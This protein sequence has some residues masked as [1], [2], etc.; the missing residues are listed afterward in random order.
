MRHIALVS[1]VATV[2]LVVHPLRAAEPLVHRAELDAPVAAVWKAFTDASE[3]KQWM[4]PLVE[5]DLRVGGLMRSNYNADGTLGDENT[6]ENRILAFEPECMLSIRAV[7]APKD[8]PFADLI[9]ETWSVMHF[10]PL[11]PNRT[12]IRLVGMGYGEGKQ[13]KQMRDFFQQGNQ[14]TLDRLREHLAKTYPVPVAT[15]A[16]A[17]LAPL[18]RFIGEWRTHGTWSDGRALHARA[19][20]TWGINKQLIHGKT[21]V[22]DDETG[23]NEYQRYE[24][25]FHFDPA[26]NALVDSSM[27]VNGTFK[28]AFI[29]PVDADTT[30]W[31]CSPFN[32]DDV[33]NVRQT[34]R[35]EDDD[36]FIW[37]VLMR[38]GDS[39]SRLI[40]SR[41][42]REKADGPR[43]E[44]SD[45]SP[46]RPQQ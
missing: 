33:V 6:I 4:V 18:A 34:I 1:F 44:A 14:W 45:T 31:G 28:Q 9:A 24:S 38:D 2:L 26:R 41:W 29:E 11:S 32:P 46:G 15:D 30:S 21:W 42:T 37:T 19:S 20:Y 3:M 43:G 35:F 13:W 7:K 36:N 5:I 22:A 8:F 39:W 27:A 10:E 16:E 23:S 17:R 25:T 40:E 12:R